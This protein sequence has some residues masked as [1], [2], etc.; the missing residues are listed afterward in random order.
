MQ[1]VER[2]VR[3]ARALVEIE[4]ELVIGGPIECDRL[5]PVERED[6]GRV[7]LFVQYAGTV[8]SLLGPVGLE[9]RERRELAGARDPAGRVDGRAEVA[10]DG[11]GGGLL[12]DDLVTLGGSRGRHHR[13]EVD[14]SVRIGEGG[15]LRKKVRERRGRRRPRGDERARASTVPSV[16]VSNFVWPA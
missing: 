5:K 3:I 11:A 9:T 1:T 2:Q 6:M 4:L 8:E 13:G 14:V 7:A 10:P 15:R 12:V 16:A